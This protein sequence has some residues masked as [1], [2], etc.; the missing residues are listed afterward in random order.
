MNTSAWGGHKLKSSWTQLTLQYGIAA[1]ACGWAIWM[2]YQYRLQGSWL[3]LALPMIGSVLLALKVLMIV[4]QF[5]TSLPQW[6]PIR[7]LLKRMEFSAGLLIR[8]FVYSSLL[9]YANG[10]LDNNPPVY[11]SAEIDSEGWK[12]TAG[13]PAPYSWVTL[14]YRDNPEDTTMVLITWEEQRKLW[15]AQPVSVTLKNGLLGIPS[16]TTIEQDWGWFGNEI[17]KLA[18][19]ATMIAQRK[20][21]FDLTHDRWGEG[22]DAARQ[23]LELNQNDWETAILAGDLL[24]QASHYHDSLPFLEHAM[25]QRPTY[26][27]MQRYGLSL[28]WAG[29]SPRAA[30]VFKASIPLDPNNWEAYYHLGYVYGDMGQYEEAIEYFEET[31]KRQPSSLEAKAMIAKHR[32]DITWRDSQKRSKPTKVFSPSTR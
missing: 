20:I 9:W 28:N 22:I 15:G 6:D 19:T 23:Y 17:L 31:L 29:Q 27:N 1:A 13:L 16:V 14:R 21:D 26:E 24:F 12:N 7:C 10:I 30:E 32:Q 18:P 5:A 25:K 3:F 8:L 2:Q 4:N 11:R